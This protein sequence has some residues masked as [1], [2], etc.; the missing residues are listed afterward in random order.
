MPITAVSNR[1]K[2]CDRLHT[3]RIDVGGCSGTSRNQPP[4]QW[5]PG[6]RHRVASG[7]RWTP[8]PIGA[9]ARAFEARDGIRLPFLQGE[10]GGAGNIADDGKRQAIEAIV[11]LRARFPKATKADLERAR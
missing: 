5:R 3:Y 9:V 11:E 4:A 7:V 6:V 8:T 10:Y 1:S 2:M